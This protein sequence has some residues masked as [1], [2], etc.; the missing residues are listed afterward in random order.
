[1][2]V[3]P[4]DEAMAKRIFQQIREHAKPEQIDGTNRHVITGSFANWTDQE[5]LSHFRNA[6]WRWYRVLRGAPVPQEAF[7]PPLTSSGEIKM[8]CC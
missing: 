2:R 6:V 7:G 3:A 1:M 5:A 4:R 8:G